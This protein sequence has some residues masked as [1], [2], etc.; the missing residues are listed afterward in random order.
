MA[1][2]TWASSG[3]GLL[4]EMRAAMSDKT[5][6][7]VVEPIQGEGGVNVPAD[8]YL[9][10]LRAL[11]DEHDWLLMLDEVQCGN[12]RTGS[13]YACQGFGVKPDIIT[14]AKALAN[15]VPIGVCMAANAAASVFEVGHHGSTYGGNPLACA[16]ALAV[17]DTMNREGI[18]E[19]AVSRGSQLRELLHQRLDGV[20]GLVDIRGRGLMVGVELAEPCAELVGQALAQGLLINV[21]AGN[22]I[23]LLPPLILSEAETEQLADGVAGLVKGFLESREH[24]T[25]NG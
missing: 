12:C 10:A 5:A 2:A 1:L 13:W 25:A 22:T 3:N 21:T 19:R 9:P 24:D 14:T 11:C 6:A 7:I 18:A 20:S 4:N 16:A 17:I 8:D 15:G 23:R